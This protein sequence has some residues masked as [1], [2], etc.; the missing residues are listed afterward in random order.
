MCRLVLVAAK[1]K[2]RSSRFVKWV[3]LSE[4][5]GEREKDFM[6]WVRGMS[7]K[8]YKI[9]SASPCHL[10]GGPPQLG[11]EP[12]A[13]RLEGERSTTALNGSIKP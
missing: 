3:M 2:V 9:S 10:K 7:I 1:L 13:F 11:F 4:R 12:W 5:A 8:A 6:M